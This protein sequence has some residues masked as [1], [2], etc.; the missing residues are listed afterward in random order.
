M[1]EYKNLHEII[2]LSEEEFE[3]PDVGVHATLDKADLR[4]LRN[5]L[6]KNEELEKMVELM[7][8]ELSLENALNC[9]YKEYKG[10][11]CIRNDDFDCK[12]SREKCKNCIKEFYKK[13]A[14]GE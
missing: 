10:H 5:L 6:A 14:K 3:N 4:E 7:V 13:K 12:Y 8:D 1:E 2:Q 9:V 11:E